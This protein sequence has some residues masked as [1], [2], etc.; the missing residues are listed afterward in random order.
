MSA[1]ARDPAS[2]LRRAHFGL[3]GQIVRMLAASLHIFA[4]SVHIPITMFFI[5]DFSDGG[6]LGELVGGSVASNVSSLSV[7]AALLHHGVSL[8]FDNL[9]KPMGCSMSGDV[10]VDFTVQLRV[11]DSGTNGLVSM[12]HERLIVGVQRGTPC[13]QVRDPSIGMHLSCA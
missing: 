12:S 13:E 6:V 10:P 9:R 7:G 4:T 2:L 1:R 5:K 8:D 3:H 11:L